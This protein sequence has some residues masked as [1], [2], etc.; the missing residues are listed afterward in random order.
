[1]SP[2]LLTGLALA[3]LLLLPAA[4]GAPTALTV[5]AAEGAL[6][7]GETLLLAG[8]APAGWLITATNP[9]GE[10]RTTVR[11][12]GSWSLRVRVPF[13]PSLTRITATSPDGESELKVDFSAFSLG[14][15]D[16]FAVAFAQVETGIRWIT[17]DPV[18]AELA[19]LAPGLHL[20][21][22]LALYLIG[23]IPG[24][25]L[26][27]LSIDTA[28]R[29]ELFGIVDPAQE[30][31]VYGDASVVERRA[32]SGPLYLRI[33]DRGTLSAFIIGDTS[34]RLAGTASRIGRF[35]RP[36]YGADGTLNL[37]V[38]ENTRLQVRLVAAPLPSIPVRDELLGTGGS[39]YLL[40]GPRLDPGM[41]IRR[42]SAS[43]RVERRTPAGT[44]LG[45]RNLEREDYLLDEAT[46]VLTLMRPLPTLDEPA[47]E[48]WLVVLYELTADSAFSFDLT[49]S[50]L[51]ARAQLSG[52]GFQAGAHYARQRNAPGDLDLLAAD[53]A[54]ELGPVGVQ[55]ELVLSSGAV[56]GLVRVSRDAG[57][58]YVDAPP[59]PG[60][61]AGAGR[62]AV[63]LADP[64]LPVRAALELEHAGSGFSNPGA[65]V[66]PG[67]TALSGRVT[68]DPDGPGGFSVAAHA[69]FRWL[70]GGGVADTY[71]AVLAWERPESAARTLRYV[72]LIVEPGSRVSADGVSGEVS[73]DGAARIELPDGA[74]PVEVSVVGPD[75]TALTVLL[76]P[77]AEGVA[78][79]AGPLRRA[80]ARTVQVRPDG[81]ADP[82][83]PTRV[84]LDL[85]RRS[86]IDRVT[87][88][89]A[90]RAT[91]TPEPGARFRLGGGYRVTT[92][93]GI[94]EGA[95][96]I[97][98]DFTTRLG[99]TV[100]AFASAELAI[101]QTP[102]PQF[103]FGLVG[104]VLSG[105]RVLGEYRVQGA[106]QA[107]AAAALGIDGRWP[108]AP[109]LRA[110]L[111]FQTVF[112]I[113]AATRQDAL[114]AGLEYRGEGGDQA[115]LRV[116]ISQQ[117]PAAGP[118]TTTLSFGAALSGRITEGLNG[119]ALLRGTRSER[120]GTLAALDLNAD[121]GLAWRPL[122]SDRLDLLARAQ[123]RQRLLPEAAPFPARFEEVVA[124]S[125]EAAF[126]VNPEPAEGLWWVVVYPGLADPPADRQPGSGLVEGA[127]VVGEYAGDVPEGRIRFSTRGSLG[128]A[129]E[130]PADR[131]PLTTGVVLIAR[132][133]L[134]AG[135]Y[136]VA[137]YDG[138]GRL[139]NAGEV[140]S[141]GRLEVEMEL[142][143]KVAASLRGATRSTRTESQGA[144]A[145]GFAAAVVGRLEVDFTREAFGAVEVRGTFVPQAMST[146]LN[147]RAELGWR[148]LANLDLYLAFDSSSY[149]DVTALDERFGQRGVSLGARFKY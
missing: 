138:R 108:V 8:T 13:G 43:V 99:G 134:A 89:A 111:G 74:G 148:L 63:D 26:L 122:F 146:A 106:A 114:G 129:I 79:E 69:A 139:L 29:Q 96:V 59:V 20:D 5:E 2:R 91:W 3:L 25:L 14:L 58:T 87:A 92:T 141:D 12:D 127:V 46:G 27:E 28:R 48:N 103:T 72:D 50:V 54:L 18:E 140:A 64:A 10:A 115:A 85:S 75:G 126:L 60:A 118:A 7:V 52:D 24:S 17:G 38:G 88:E 6:A 132:T 30:Y 149:L 144:V 21:G 90:L 15:E 110:N 136:V 142:W 11:M 16:A 62:I 101:G 112:G 36:V 135:E 130:R 49:R 47:V 145:Y 137:L 95:A 31:P 77:D 124:L 19:G 22:R 42:G 68:F 80:V 53:T 113:T 44:L 131:V 76:A 61:T 34:G 66:Q 105:I 133:E 147:L 128:S 70:A 23:R 125:A 73:V 109:G 143:R 84:E 78:G 67:S 86:T 102:R 94:D 116:E 40:S 41:I 121:L 33:E 104:E 98:A 39:V 9:T 37:P 123:W 4:A 97:G 55:A 1:M 56:G 35:G 51:A 120:A 65:S 107:S 57:V 83:V 81:P 45:V 93:A 119:S 100:D 117:T 71:G 82:A 32:A